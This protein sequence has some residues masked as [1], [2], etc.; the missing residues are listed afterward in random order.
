MKFSFAISARRCFGLHAL[1][2]SS[3]NHNLCVIFASYTD[4]SI[5]I[6]EFYISFILTWI[7][8][9]EQVSR[10]NDQYCGHQNKF[11]FYV[12][13]MSIVNINI[14]LKDYYDIYIYIYIWIILRYAFLIVRQRYFF[15]HIFLERRHVLGKSPIISYVDHQNTCSIFVLQNVFRVKAFSIC[16]AQS[17][18]TKWKIFHSP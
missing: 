12:K 1:S 13:S 2:C 5:L 11:I 4:I 15:A 14:F 17:K 16:E 3:F 7:F 8:G 10:N 6:I 18:T 9:P